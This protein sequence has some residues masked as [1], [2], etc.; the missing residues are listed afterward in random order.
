M[1]GA[2]FRIG[3]SIECVAENR[4]LIQKLAKSAF[5]DLSESGQVLIT[6]LVHRQHQDQARRDSRRLSCFCCHQEG[7]KNEDCDCEGRAGAMHD[8]NISLGAVIHLCLSNDFVQ[9]QV[10]D[11]RSNVRPASTND[12]SA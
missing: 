6:H 1:S 3:M 9:R 7:E 11:Y 10:K 8:V 12:V 2:G 4:P 5:E